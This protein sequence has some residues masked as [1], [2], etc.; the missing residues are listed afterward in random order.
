MESKRNQAADNDSD[1][2]I[3]IFKGQEQTSD[4]DDTGKNDFLI[5]IQTSFQREMFKKFGPATICM[6]STHGTNVYDF[7]LITNL[8]L[9]DLGEG[10]LVGRIVSNR[11]DAA[12]IRQVLSRIKEK[13]GDINTSIFMSDDAN[14]FFNAWRGVFTV[15]N[16]NKVI[17]AWHVVVSRG[18]TYVVEYIYI[19]PRETRHVDKSWRKELQNHMSS[20]A[21]QAEDYHHLHVLLSEERTEASF[22]L[23]L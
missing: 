17:C 20:R 4:V 13:C 22:Q 1:N 6:D 3:L 18:Q 7:Y 9:D 23:R 11:E 15:T 21:R 10:V 19:W 8:V 14:N 5:G 12:I 2:P 16:T